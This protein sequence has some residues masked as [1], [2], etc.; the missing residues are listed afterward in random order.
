VTSLNREIEQ[1]YDLSPRLTRVLAPRTVFVAQDV[2]DTLRL[3]EESFQ[4]QSHEKLINASGKEDLG[5]GAAVGITYALQNNQI[6]FEDR[7]T[8]VETG[9]ITTD[10]SGLI[11]GR[12]SVI[13]SAATFQTNNV[14]RGSFVVNWTDQTIV[15][16]QDVIS[17]TE[18]TVRPP[19]SGITND[20]TIG[21]AYSVFNVERVDLSG[22][23]ATAVDD[24][25]ASIDPVVPSV[26]TYAIITL[27]TS[28][29]IVEGLSAAAV[30]GQIADIHGQVRRAIY[31]N[32]AALVNGNGYQQTP[33]N[34]WTDGVDDAEANGL[35][36]LYLED[37]AT[38]DRQLKN[39]E[40]YGIDLPSLTLNG[41]IMDGSVL[42]LVAID[43]TQ[44]GTG[45]LILFDCQMTNVTDFNGAG[46][47]IGAVG[48]I[49][50]R[51]GGNS[52]LNQLVPFTTG[53]V[54]LDFT[55]GGAATNVEANNVSGDYTITNMDNAGDTLHLAM[56]HGEVTIDASCTLGTIKLTGSAKLINNSGG[57]TVDSKALIQPSTLLTIKKFIGLQ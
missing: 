37:D 29:S 7:E 50:F 56:N 19:T 30:S 31:I 16:V 17:E 26:G 32:T 36:V 53:N 24:V 55:L 45:S 23:N 51:N 39:F 27:S 54:T 40:I 35:Q 28:A 22:G 3:T 21:D 52:I 41:Q 43:G 13:D 57:T 4:G 10:S 9:T 14:A 25:A 38:V 6:Q 15:S 48:T 20:Y 34:N 47:L 5:G 44:G 33:Y 49:A 12:I 42:R 2:V 1:D 46:S 11:G 18:L 8:P